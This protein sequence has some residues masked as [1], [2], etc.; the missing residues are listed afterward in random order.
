ML[1][2]GRVAPASTGPSAT[3]SSDASGSSDGRRFY[4]FADGRGAR[5]GARRRLGCGN[6]SRTRRTAPAAAATT[7]G[8]EHDRPEVHRPPCVLPP[9]HADAETEEQTPEE[10]RRSGVRAAAPCPSTSH[11]RSVAAALPGTRR[12]CRVPR[13]RSRRG[14]RVLPACH[15]SSRSICSAV[16]SPASI[17]PGSFGLRPFENIT[18][19]APMMIAAERDQACGL[20]QRVAVE[21]DVGA[22]TRSRQPSPVFTTSTR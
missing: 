22:C 16:P 20:R 3:S 12:A 6:P 13:S 7:S 10:R 2:V 11:A 14:T 18:P 21:L 5:P 19:I 1:F 17:Q 4:R 8:N 15:A 9:E